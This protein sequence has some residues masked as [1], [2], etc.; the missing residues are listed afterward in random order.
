MSP[1]LRPAASP[2][3]VLSRARLLP[4]ISPLHE[5][6]VSD[7]AD[8]CLASGVPAL[9]LLLRGDGAESAAVAAIGRLAAT[10]PRLAVG[11]GTVFDAETAQRAIG[12]GARIVVS[13]ITDADTGAAC[14][15]AGVDWLPGAF[16]PTEIALAERAGAT[17][18][19]LFPA[20]AI[21]APA[22]LR[23]VL[24]TRPSSRIVPTNVSIEEIPALVAAGAAGFGVGERLLGGARGADAIAA[25]L[26]AALLAAGGTPIDV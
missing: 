23:S 14:R 15:A 16:T 12:A 6:E 9:E 5:A 3:A 21:D 13:P 2:L 11:V 19:K 26:R 1:D 8:A 25:K 24:A 20:L 18:V 4:A 7:W 17:Q 22:F 10:H